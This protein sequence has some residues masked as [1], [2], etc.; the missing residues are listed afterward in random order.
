M[1]NFKYWLISL[2]LI[3]LTALP[4]QAAN[5][6]IV[7]ANGVRAWVIEDHILPIV[8]IQLT[9][10]NAGY[11]YDP[12]GREGLGFEVASM[13]NEGAGIYNSQEFQKLLEENAIRFGPDVSKDN[14]YL[15]L[16]TL[17]QNL[18][19][20]LD[21]TD[22]ALSSPHFAADDLARIKAQTLSIIRKKSE[23]QGEIAADEFAKAVFGSH[24]YARPQ[25]GTAPSINKIVS[26]DLQR[27]TRDKFGKDNLLISIVGD[28]DETTAKDIISKI[29]QHLPEDSKTKD[30][31]EFRNFPKAKLVK[32]KMDNP[33]TYVIFGEEGISRKDKDFYA[34]YLLNHILGGG[35][36]SA[37]LMTEVRQKNGLAYSVGT[38]LESFDRANLFTGV[39]AT[40]T[41]SVDKSIT[42]TRQE[43]AKIAEN[44][45]TARELKDAKDFITGSF[46]L[47]LDKN[48]N[49]AAFLTVMQLYDLGPDYLQ[50]RNDYFKTVTLNQVNAAAKRLIRPENLVFVRVGR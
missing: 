45:V 27:F 5:V 13:L 30:L 42:I 6:K 25:E 9:F 14:F 43:L 8:A 37:R 29:T 35:G 16:K 28:V 10:K 38:D 2:F 44:G 15:S 49:L 46:G 24:P 33:Q 4:A 47:N 36:F 26:A 7:E 48:E 3:L 21:L 41:D 39:L 20:A 40:R 1:R 11:A 23:S 31:P 32:L 34:A 22:L 12:P 18:D 50:K 17:T 19:L